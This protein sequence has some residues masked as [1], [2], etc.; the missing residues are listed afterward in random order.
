MEFNMNEGHPIEVEVGGKRYARHAIRTRFV[1]IGE[2]YLD[3]IREYVLPV[4]QPGD[5]L[6]SSEKVVAL[7]QGRVVYEK[8]VEPGLLARFLAP[9]ASGTPDAFGVKHPAKMQF[10]INECG[11]PRVLWAAICA[12]V[13]KLFGKHG[14]FYEMTGRE[15]AGLDG[16]YGAEFD[17]YAHMGVRIPADPDGVCDEVERELGVQMMIVD[18]NNINVEILGRSSSLALTD[19][20][21]RALIADN[22]AGQGTELTPFILI[23]PL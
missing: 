9:F 8:D 3:L 6:S 19:D 11:A 23:R 15:V 10:A 13:A 17:T 16:F 21:L 2:S 5:I 1:E 4:W 7:C 12:G 20:D 22:P 18:A 14:V